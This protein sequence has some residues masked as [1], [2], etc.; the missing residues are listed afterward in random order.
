MIDVTLVNFEAEVITA[1]LRA[2]VLVDVW[3]EWCGPCKQLGPQLELLETEYAGRFALAKLDA[4]KVPEIAGQLSQMFGTRS[5]PLCVLFVQ[6]QPVDGFVGAL[7]PAQLRAFLDK[8]VPS[9]GALE[10]EAEVDEAH[11]LLDAGDTQAALAKMADALAADPTN[12]DA[13]FDYV[14]LLIGTGAYEEAQALLHEPLARIPKP[15]RFE[16]LPHWLGALQFVQQDDR[17]NWPLE[18]FDAQIAQNKRD[19]ETRFA[20]ARVLMAEGQWTAAMDELLEIILRDKAW[21]DGAARKTYVAILELL[22]PPK[23]KA[24]AGVPGKSAGGIELMGKAGAQEDEATALL[25]SYRRKLSMAL[26]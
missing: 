22:T 2:P 16:A 13:R 11:A 24:D 3:A 15:L 20:K 1:S 21:Q 25:N 18:Q 9:E 26:N 8:H 6:G 14:R 10:A 5:I 4:D 19:F 7:P 23:P 17:G 12:D